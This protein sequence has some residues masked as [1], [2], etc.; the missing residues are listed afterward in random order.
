MLTLL[1]IKDSLEWNEERK[2]A[3]VKPNA[4]EEVWDLI[5]DIHDNHLCNDLTC[6]LIYDI[7]DWLLEYLNEPEGSR[8]EPIDYVTYCFD[9]WVWMTANQLRWLN[10]VPDAFPRI[11]DVLEEGIKD[12]SAAIA[13]AM[14]THIEEITN[15]ILD[16]VDFYDNDSEEEEEF[17]A[18]EDAEE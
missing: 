1:Q 4:P 8:G 3:F 5:R 16:A 14:F 7:V 6:G 9:T 15:K 10:E 2:T 17:D 11:N 13:R 18:E 12:I